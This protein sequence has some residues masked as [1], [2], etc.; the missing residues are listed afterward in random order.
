MLH[1]RI[2]IVANE[3]SGIDVDKWDYFAR[4]CQMLGIRNSFDHTRSIALARVVNVKNEEGKSVRTI[5][6]REKVKSTKKTLTE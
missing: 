1:F 2:K 3:K 6:F 4:D 5:S